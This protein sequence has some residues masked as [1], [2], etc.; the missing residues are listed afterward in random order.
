MEFD[1][2]IF[3]NLKWQVLYINMVRVVSVG[4]RFAKVDHMDS[5]LIDFMKNGGTG[6]GK[7]ILCRS[8]W[9]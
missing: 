9:R 4:T 1:V 2:A 3:S 5:G 8:I 6:L 7:P